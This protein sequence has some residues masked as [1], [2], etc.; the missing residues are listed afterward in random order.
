[1]GFPVKVVFTEDLPGGEYGHCNAELG[2]VR[3]SSELEGLH[4][5]A[6]VL[7]E[8][9]HFIWSKTQK[10]NSKINEEEFC[11]KCELFASLLKI[12]SSLGVDK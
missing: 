5:E 1:M 2:E 4:R 9:A 11:T 10:A 12:S 8:L 7:H 6:V 3:I